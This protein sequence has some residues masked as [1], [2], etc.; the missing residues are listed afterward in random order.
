MEIRNLNNPIICGDVED[1]IARELPWETFRGKTV[2]VTG[3]SGMI[4]SYAVYTFLGLNDA[5]DLGVRVLA[6]VRNEEK[7]RRIFGKVLERDDIEL[8]AQDVSAPIE[9]TGP[10]DYIIHGASAARPSEHKKA[11]TAT[12]RANLMGTFN[13]LDL[14]V[15]KGAEGFVLMSS[16]EVYGTVPEGIKEITETDYG[17]LDI[18]NP[19]SCYSEGKRGAETICAAYQAQYGI[20]CRIPRFA[21]IYGPGMSLNDGRVQADFAAN[22]YRGQN[23]VLKSDGSSQRA[24]TYVADAVA[25][26]FYVLLKGEDMAYNVADSRHIISI[27]ELAEAFVAARP[28]K[29]L[30]LVFDIPEGTGGM[31]NPAAFIGLSGEKLEGLGWEPVNDIHTGCVKMV[32]SYD[33]TEESK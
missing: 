32:A 8:I 2:L 1:I 5:K 27:R 20:R 23:I 25:G 24:Y 12:I 18:L 10:V 15:E 16:S 17:A 31:Y 9:V 33:Y 14:A 28:E 21:H 19:R 4:P 3:A 6:L 29:N 22:V 26:M 30:K 7:A 11:P 13:L